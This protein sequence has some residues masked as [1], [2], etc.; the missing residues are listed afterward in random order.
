MKYSLS[1]R[2]K[3]ELS[4][5]LQPFLKKPSDK[6]PI[7]LELEFTKS[8]RQELVMNRPAPPP[9]EF[10]LQAPII[11]FCNDGDFQPYPGVCRRNGAQGMCRQRIQIERTRLLQYATWLLNF[12]GALSRMEWNP[13]GGLHFHIDAWRQDEIYIPR[14][15]VYMI[16][17][18]SILATL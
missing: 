3:K 12:F 2:N 6:N 8:R 9:R 4:N 14:S 10:G 5:D 16:S 13:I 7:V 18:T 17:Q 11:K 1:L 15:L